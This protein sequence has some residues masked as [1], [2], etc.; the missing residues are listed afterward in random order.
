MVE[1]A[2]FLFLGSDEPEKRKKLELLKDKYFPA[3][4]KDL[5]TTVLHADDKKLSPQMLTEALTLAPTAGASRRLVV[6]KMAQKMNEALQ[7]TARKIDPGALAGTALVLD[8]PETKGSEALVAYWK[9]RGAEAHVFKSASA[10]DVFELGRAIAGRHTAAALKILGG[11]YPA[12]E[13]PEKLLGGLLW[14][15]ERL[16]S[17]KPLSDEAYEQ[18]I[19]AFCEADKRLKTSYAAHRQERLILETLVVKLSYLA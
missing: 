15:W 17:D 12:R 9:K 6:I 3:S 1:S 16:R 10:S 2:L 18:G 19:K 13:R 8:I 7:E 4:L 11:L 5:N 14:Q